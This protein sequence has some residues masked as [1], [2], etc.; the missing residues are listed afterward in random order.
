MFQENW[1]LRADKITIL[2]Q[3]RMRFLQQSKQGKQEAFQFFSAFLISPF[4]IEIII[5]IMTEQ[6][7]KNIA[8]G[9]V[10]SIIWVDK[11]YPVKHSIEKDQ[12]LRKRFFLRFIDDRGLFLF[13]IGAYFRIIIEPNI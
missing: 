3:L 12:K 10:L 9:I 1:V 8:L 4:M 6:V 7:E 5:N 2:R 13:M 11:T